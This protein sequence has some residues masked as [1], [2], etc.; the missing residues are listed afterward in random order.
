MRHRHEPGTPSS[1]ERELRVAARLATAA[2]EILLRHRRDGLRTGSKEG[3][4]IVTAA[5]L[6]I[7]RAIRQGLAE[8]FPDDALLSE[9]APDDGRRLSARRTWIVDP[10]DGTQD[11]ANGGD[12][13]GIS[14]GLAVDGRAVLGVVHNPVRG[15]LFA[16]T[17]TATDRALTL[18]GAPVATASGALVEAA[19]LTVSGTEWN[20]GEY[21][22][23]GSLRLRPLSSAAYKLARVAAG[24]D[25]GTFWIWPRKEWD[26]CAGVALV[27][28]GGGAVTLL[29][30][31]PIRFNQR[32]LRLGGGVVASGTSLHE[33][34]RQQIRRVGL[35]RMDRVRA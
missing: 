18:G 8:T 5:D 25:D 15:E 1:L 26:V 3:G 11:Y 9:E 21:R 30:G 33:P 35:M 2:G 7:D 19:E 34:L 32:D 20:A 6:A 14:I 22:S 24:L 29:D 23:A 4:E 16:G 17:V 12:A 27:L 31:S 13:H 28:A 10:I